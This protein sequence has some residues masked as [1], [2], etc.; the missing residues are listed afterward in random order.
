MV[1]C[2]EVAE[3]PTPHSR[4]MRCSLR[5]EDASL[6]AVSKLRGWRVSVIFLFD[7]IVDGACMETHT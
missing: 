3:L 4:A 2:L 6:D 1:L 5:G 7:E